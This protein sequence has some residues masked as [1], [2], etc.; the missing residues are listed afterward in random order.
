[1]HTI[2]ATPGANGSITP[3]GPIMVNCGSNQTF[4]IM[5]NTCYQID[6]VI[7]NGVNKGA[8]TS[9]TFTNVRGD[10]TI[11]TVYKIKKH[12]ITATAGSNGT[13][14]PSGAVLVNCGSG[15]T[16]TITPNTCYQIDS[17]I[18][19]DVS[20]GAISSYTFNNVTGDSTIRAVFRILTYTLTVTASDSGSVTKSPNQGSYNCGTNVQ[21]AAVPN[22]GY[23]FSGWA[24]DTTG[25]TN[26]MTIPMFKNRIITAVFAIDHNL[27]VPAK[28]ATIQSAAGFA[29]HG[30]TISV[31]PGTYNETVTIDGK[32]SLT[33]IATGAVD[34]VTVKGFSISTCSNTVVRGFVVDAAGSGQRGIS[35]F[36]GTETQNDRVTIES[37][38]I[39]NASKGIYLTGANNGIRIVNNRIHSN[40]TNGVELLDQTTGN[41]VYL[42][43]NTITKCGYNGVIA[44]AEQNVSLVNNCIAF[45][46]TA[47]GTSG[48]RYGIYRKLPSPGGEVA[49][50]SITPGPNPLGIK[51]LNNFIV[52]NN[53]QMG[54]GNSK[55]L[56]NYTQILDATDAGNLTTAG[57]EGVGVS[58]SPTASF[59]TTFVSSS[60]VDLH[61]KTGAVPINRGVNSW[62][63]DDPA[64]GAIPSKDFEGTTRPQGGTVDMGGDEY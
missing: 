35:I 49:S 14:T 54:T 23:K 27:T 41:T 46:G 48:G 1:T 50:Q 6:S 25:I 16:F 22:L 60:P 15:Q 63:P 7:V 64:A 4:T 61:L 37:N 3:S 55:D 10:S 56:Y 8:I 11:R 45:N 57:N 59:S 40:T 39:K 12:T 5:A 38:Q 17:V 29:R 43:N 44:S 33:I 58:Q 47:S 28:F 42:I 2:S 31:S 51:L 9:Y 52:G 21:L 26:P 18:V 19:N 53:G 36:G 20:K 30:D 13:I 24:G 32:D 62:T 34:Q